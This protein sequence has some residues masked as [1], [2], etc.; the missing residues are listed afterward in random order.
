[1]AEPALRKVT[2]AT[3]SGVMRR[4]GPLSMVVISVSPAIVVWAF[5]VP[6]EA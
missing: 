5:H 6:F 4:L 3:P 2:C 1:V